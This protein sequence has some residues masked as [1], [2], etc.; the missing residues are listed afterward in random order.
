MKRWRSYNGIYV[1]LAIAAMLF[2]AIEWYYNWREQAVTNDSDFGNFGT[3]I[4]GIWRTKVPLSLYEGEFE[5]CTRA[6]H[7]EWMDQDWRKLADIPSGTLIKIDQLMFR[8]DFNTQH[9]WV[10]G[11]FKEGMYAGDA[12]YLSPDFIPEEIML[13]YGIHGRGSKKKPAWRVN[14]EMLEKAN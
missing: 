2:I 4:V 6:L 12:I 5:N 8:T 14:P 1:I 10:T 7:G 3:V 11:I 13:H 9:L